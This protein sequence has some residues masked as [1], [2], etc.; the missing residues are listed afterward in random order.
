M[1]AQTD[2][3]RQRTT[4]TRSKIVEALFELIEEGNLV[5]T[6]EEV[7]ER[8]DVGLRTVFRHFEDMDSL[9][10]E[11]QGKLELILRPLFDKGPVSGSLDER[12]ES[13][14]H[15]R[16]GL[17]EKTRAFRRATEAR[18]WQSPYL[19]ASRTAHHKEMRRFM[20]R[21]LPECEEGPA[22]VRRTIE[23]LLSADAWD[24]MR[25]GQGLSVK[26]CE[27]TLVDALKKLMLPD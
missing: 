16:G 10:A 27:R 2:G 6:S 19:R 11:L 1:P 4:K 24:Q 17:F 12:I 21:H 23:T 26:E 18:R 13:L 9:Y 22:Y 14:V 3:R 5:P 7:A 8:A 25:E 15:R 20:M